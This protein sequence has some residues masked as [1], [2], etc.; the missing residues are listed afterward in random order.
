MGYFVNQYGKDLKVSSFTLILTLLSIISLGS[1]LNYYVAMKFGIIN[2]GFVLTNKG[3][4]VF[5]ITS[6]ILLLFK[7]NEERLKR[8]DIILSISDASFG[9]YLIHPFLL[10]ITF[11][12]LS[13]YEL[14]IVLNMLLSFL[15]VFIS[16]L[17]II[18]IM[19]RIKYI[20]AVC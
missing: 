6:M 11:S 8:S 20:R 14:N 15:V 5:I 3:P 13:R 1:L 16:S 10:K 4:I 9:I 18:R 7:K 17:I 19:K 12:L 2:D